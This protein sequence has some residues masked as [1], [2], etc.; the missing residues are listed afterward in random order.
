MANSNNMHKL[1]IMTRKQTVIGLLVVMDLVMI[2]IAVLTAGAIRDLLE[3]F[4]GGAVNWRL[5]WSG[6]VLYSVFVVLLSWANG[7]YPGFGLAAVHEMRK[8][9]V[10]ISLASIFLGVYLFLQQIAFLYSRF[11]FLLSWVLSAFLMMI[12]RFALRNIFSHFPWWGIPMVVIGSR[13]TISTAIEKLIKNR[14]LGYRPYAY[15]NPEQPGQEPILGVPG[16]QDKKALENLVREMK[17]N[18]VLYTDAIR[19]DARISFQWLRELF[20]N[21]LFVLSDT[22]FGSLW[23]RPIDLHGTLLIET[24]YHLLSNR[25]RIFKRI[26]DLI[27]TTFLLLISW[28]LFLVLAILVKITSKGPVIYTQKRLGINGELFDSYK[29]RTM[30]EN[31]GEKLKELLTR[32]KAAFEEY[33]LYH[34]LQNDPRITPIGRFIR[35]FSLD[36][37]PQLFNVLKGDM[38]LIGPRSY[39][40]WE[41]FAMGD[42]SRIILKVKPGLTGWWQVMG[43]NATSF[44][45]RLALDQYYISNW[46]LWLDIYIMIKTV[47]VVLSGQGR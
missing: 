34:K 7:L 42:K 6:L 43:R 16:I 25:E 46:S 47:F 19:K 33:T 10:V 9:M 27:L 38:N 18:Y 37:L 28:P 26:M 4:L 39:M 15:F 14:R 8:V 17:L 24:N 20:P 36:E 40:P 35:R 44:E 11:I 22:P 13:D 29:F 41:Q 5:L 31:A 12:G 45:E 30:Y 23:I 1:T 2:T 3:P 32:D 21:V